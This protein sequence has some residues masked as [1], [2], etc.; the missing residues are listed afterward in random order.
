MIELIL[1]GMAVSVMA[2]VAA[3]D[4]ES[5]LLWG[6]VTGVLAGVFIFTIPLPFLRVLLA[7]IATVILMVVYKSYRK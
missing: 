7:A 2:K 1:A 5:P 4:R 6:A 3:N